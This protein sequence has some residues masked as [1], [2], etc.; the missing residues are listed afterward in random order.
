M[1]RTR[2]KLTDKQERIIVQCQLMGLTTSDMIQ[3][4]NRLRALEKEKEF[5]HKVDEIMQDISWEAKK[6]G[7]HY[8]LKESKGKTYEFSISKKRSSWNSN[9]WDVVITNPGTRMKPRILTDLSMYYD[10]NDEIASV[11][12]NKDRY[13]FRLASAIKLKRLT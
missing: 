6:K 12:P 11:C 7:E 4:S 9:S 5:K 2:A 3:I 10:E 1:P 8:I 13:I